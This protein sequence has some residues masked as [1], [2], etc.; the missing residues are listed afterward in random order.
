MKDTHSYSLLG[1]TLVLLALFAPAPAQTGAA[2][3]AETLDTETLKRGI[4]NLQAH[5][6]SR[7]TRITEL[8]NDI[9]TLDGRIE[10][11]V[12]K[13]VE[14]LKGI[15]DSDQSGTNVART[16]ADIIEGLKRSIEYYDTKRRGLK[17]ETMKRAPKMT[18]DDLF[19]DI[20]VFDERIEKRIGQILELAN[21]LHTHEDIDKWKYT[22]DDSWIG[23]GYSRTRNPEYYHNRKQTQG[24]EQ[25]K[26]QL[27]E[28]LNGS[29]DRIDS[30][31][32]DIRETLKKEITPQYR[33][34]LDTELEKNEGTIAAR[35]SQIADLTLSKQGYAEPMGR[36]QMSRVEDLI[37]DMTKDL[38]RDFNALFENYAEL[39]QERA[40][41]KTIR[42]QL[43][44]YQGMLKEK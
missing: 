41:L 8:T 31:N 24:T 26:G 5:A 15:T 9:M 14:T 2:E 44:K 27:V 16:K 1:I 21:S 19:S 4:A 6:D 43:T 13:I 28:E 30:R 40:G 17:S 18:R 20:G 38:R 36:T 25:T 34:M 23:D 33:E 10:T 12:D 29:I 42:E 35:R 32:R 37:E 39:N 3:K 11:R 22:Y 7:E